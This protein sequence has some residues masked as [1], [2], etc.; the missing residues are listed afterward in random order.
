MRAFTAGQEWLDVDPWE[1]LN[2]RVSVNYTDVAARLERYLRTHVDHRIDLVFVCGADNSRFA[3]AF[4]STGGCVVV[5]RPGSEDTEASWRTD[6]RIA[7]S[8]RVLWASGDHPAASSTASAQEQTTTRPALRLRLEDER[9]VR[10]LGLAHPSWVRF[11]DAL[12]ERLSVVMDVL[13]VPIANQPEAN[14]SA[15]I[16]LDPLVGGTIDVGVSRLFDLGGAH[17]LGFVSRPGWPPIAGQLGSIPA[18]NWTVVDDDRATGD[19]IR[20]LLDQLPAEVEIDDV[21]VRMQDGAGDIADSRDFL[22]GA[23]SG[24]LVVELPDGTIGRVPYLLPYVDPSV[25]SGLP[26]DDVVAFSIDV[27]KL[28]AG[29]FDG[30]GLAVGDLSPPASAA[31]RLAGHDDSMPLADVCRWHAESL[32][33]RSAFVPNQQAPR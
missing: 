1:S 26:A 8:S 5:A 27:W 29:A 10:D 24:G 30:T 4:A 2:R 3:L 28:N 31:L 25:R 16:S 32:Q 11:Q 7:V 6:P 23:D 15:T 17:Q 19:T 33:G 9:A 12:L 18:G 20:F 21:A 13:G 22:L 14:E